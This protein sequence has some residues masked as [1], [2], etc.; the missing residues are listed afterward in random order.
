[1]QAASRRS[2]SL[3]RLMRR[4]TISGSIIHRG[5][6]AHRLI[7]ERSKAGFNHCSLIRFFQ[8]FAGAFAVCGIEWRKDVEVE[9]LTNNASIVRI[10]AVFTLNQQADRLLFDVRQTIA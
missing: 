6:T 2:S 7:F 4:S 1:M 9:T 8:N 5:I 3:R 10:Q